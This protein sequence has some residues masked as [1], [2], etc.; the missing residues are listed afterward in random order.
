MFLYLQ[1]GDEIKLIS[2]SASGLWRGCLDGKVGNFKFI[3]VEEIPNKITSQSRPT[4]NLTSR[5]SSRSRTR[6]LEELLTRLNLPH[7][8]Q[9]FFIIY[10][11][12]LIRLKVLLLQINY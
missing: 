1:K 3:L 8:V 9:V 6:T 2:K 7:L 10:N 11:V 4:S 5:R 12:I